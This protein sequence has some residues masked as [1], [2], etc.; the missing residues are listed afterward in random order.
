[1]INKREKKK[2]SHKV[3]S[4]IE[5]E[6]QEQVSL[7]N[8]SLSVLDNDTDSSDLENNSSFIFHQGLHKI[9]EVAFQNF[10]DAI[11]KD[12]E[13]K[14]KIIKTVHKISN[15]LIYQPWEIKVHKFSLQIMI[16]PEYL[17]NCDEE[18]SKWAVSAWNQLIGTVQDMNNYIKENLNIG[19]D[20]SS[21]DGDDS[22]DGSEDDSE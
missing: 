4:L 15:S 22:K 3:M 5:E 21:I 8:I 14:D 17:P 12:Y 18:D 20:T 19:N 11:P 13:N 6:R 1:M 9:G 2:Q 7:A 16:I 10:I